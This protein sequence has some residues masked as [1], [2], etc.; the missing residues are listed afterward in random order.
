[1]QSDLLDFGSLAYIDVAVSLRPTVAAEATYNG[2]DVAA[3]WKLRC[4]TLRRHMSLTVAAALKP[5][6]AAAAYFGLLTSRTHLWAR[7]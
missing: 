7:R 6:V 2:K 1:M 3:S 4:E 5:T